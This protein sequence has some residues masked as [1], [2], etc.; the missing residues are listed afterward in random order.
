MSHPLTKNRA[1]MTLILAAFLWSLGGLFIKL[2]TWHPMVIAGV[3]SGIAGIVMLAFAGPLPRRFSKTV[4]LGAVC[5]TLLAGCFI[6]SNKL[7][8]STNAILLQFTSPIWMALLTTFVLKQ[9]LHKRDFVVIVAVMVGMVLFFVGDLSIGNMLGNVLAIVAG[10]VLAVMILIMKRDPST[11]PLHMTLLGSALLFTLGLPFAFM[12]P[13]EISV[14][15]IA[16][17]LTLGIF[18][19]GLGYVLF[20]RAIHYVTPLEAVLIPVI[21][22][23]FNPIWVILFIGEK[24]SP[25]ALLGGVL[26]IGSILWKQVYEAKQGL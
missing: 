20:T 10:V 4:W 9:P 11:N 1:I 19:L 14:L 22:P 21:E 17:I 2:V 5:Y 26:V 24:P 13:P 12:Y 7:T 3:R 8:T 18:Q 23:L 6:L 16:S 25:Y 15:N